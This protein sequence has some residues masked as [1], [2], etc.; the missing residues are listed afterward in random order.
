MSYSF[1]KMSQALFIVEQ[2][3]GIQPEVLEF[4]LAHFRTLW[5]PGWGQGF[6]QKSGVLCGSVPDVFA[7]LSVVHQ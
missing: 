1:P 4:I 5:N 6:K 2:V 7:L 3:P